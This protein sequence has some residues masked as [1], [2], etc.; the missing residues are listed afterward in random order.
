MCIS[1]C[2]RRT[3]FTMP[4]FCHLHNAIVSKTL[5]RWIQLLH[6]C[7]R[8][9]RNSPTKSSRRPKSKPTSA[10]CHVSTLVAAYCTLHEGELSPEVLENLTDSGRMPVIDE[11]CA[12]R[13]FQLA[14]SVHP[15]TMLPSTGDMNT[16][17]SSTCL[18]KLCIQA[19][20]KSLE[21]I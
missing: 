5:C 8:R 17:K 3:Y 6:S 9:T 1:I 19:I 4:R 21:R 16:I 2:N 14:A 11:K 12:T 15:T 13:L 7:H 10:S 18:Q 20:S